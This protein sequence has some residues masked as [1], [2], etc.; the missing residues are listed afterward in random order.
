MDTIDGE[1]TKRNA[2]S[3]EVQNVR[4]RS[5]KTLI[6]EVNRRCELTRAGVGRVNRSPYSKAERLA[7]AQGYL[8]E[9]PVLRVK[10]YG[11]LVHVS[12]SSAC[13][14]LRLF[15]SNPANGIKGDGRGNTKVYVKWGYTDATL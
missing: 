4:Y 1:D 3:I 13:K 15:A 6:N 7:M 2:R 14:D 8:A 11:E 5:D 12:T 10:T 9:H